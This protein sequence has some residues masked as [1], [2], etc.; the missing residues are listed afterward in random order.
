MHSYVA[1]LYTMT[2]KKVK[3]ARRVLPTDRNS[4]GLSW[5]NLMNPNRY[6]A[7]AKN[8]PIQIAR[9]SSLSI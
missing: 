3:V 2:A 4:S 8:I 5:G 1:F 7:R 9:K 6:N